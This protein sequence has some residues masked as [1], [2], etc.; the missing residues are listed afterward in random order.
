MAPNSRIRV[1]A[2]G[3]N[4]LSLTTEEVGGVRLKWCSQVVV[5]PGDKRAVGRPG[6]SGAIM[7]RCTP[8]G[9]RRDE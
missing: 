3:R 8:S 1:G 6:G 4:S 7:G 2:V 9:D 5:V